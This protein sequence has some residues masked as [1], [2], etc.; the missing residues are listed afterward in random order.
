LT[1]DAKDRGC[2][3][4]RKK[5]TAG[6][7]TT[8]QSGLRIH[9]IVTGELESSLEVSL[10]NG[11]RHPSIQEKDRYP[12]GYR[13]DLV[14][15][16]GKVVSGVMVPVPVWYIAGAGRHILIDTGLGEPSEVARI[17]SLYG[18]DFI[19]ERKPEHDLVGGLAAI[20][21]KPSDIDLVVLTHLHF[22]HFG[23]NHL[24]EN[25]TF[26]TQRCELGMALAP[27]PYSGFYYKELA[28]Y[29]D[30]IRG[31][32]QGIEG[33]LELEPGIR[34]LKLGGHSPGCTA[35]MVDTAEGTVALAGDGVYN[36]KNLELNW[37][38]GAFIDMEA[39]MRG[40]DRLRSEADVIVPN[41]DWAFR[42]KYPTGVIG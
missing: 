21:V 40:F 38:M 14:R 39:V 12:F 31:R 10:L 17:Q 6:V 15:R 16:D 42:E 9:H 29:L 34:L 30:P 36:Y 5:G 32:I 2:L 18:I 8:E 23:N 20:G 1:R 35:V 33:D 37:P 3:I 22:D 28:H 41:H 26:I 25:A 27:P 19:C 13:N 11:A 4:N 7:S 24:F